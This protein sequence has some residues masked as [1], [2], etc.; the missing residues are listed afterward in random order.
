[1]RRCAVCCAT[2]TA[3]SQCG[4]CC[5]VVYCGRQCQAADWRAHHQFVCSI[6]IGLESADGV[7]IDIP[8]EQA[9]QF[10]TIAELM[11]EYNGED[12]YIPIPNVDGD[13]LVYVASLRGA[14][15]IPAITR[16]NY[17]QMIRAIHACAYLENETLLHVFASRV[18]DVL[19]AMTDATLAYDLVAQLDPF[20][21]TRYVFFLTRLRELPRFFARNFS[22]VPRLNDWV[23]RV[24][25]SK[26][27][28]R[29]R[30]TWALEWAATE[31]NGAVLDF[32]LA[33]TTQVGDAPLL[34]AIQNGHKSIVE[35]LL[36]DAR[37]DPAA[38]ISKI[39][40]IVSASKSVDVLDVLLRDGRADP[41]YDNN[42]LLNTLVDYNRVLMVK[43]LLKDTRVDPAANDSYVVY[44]AC[45]RAH[46]LML[47]ALLQDGRVDPAAAGNRA[48]LA[49]V[50]SKCVQCI[51][52]LLHAPGVDYT[53]GNGAVL[54]FATRGNHQS[55]LHHL[56]KK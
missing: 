39:W 32:L 44:V 5:N 41:A 15:D 33:A 7:R 43:R 29:L 53:A 52:L 40:I 22:D 20:L 37:V 34:L 46:I 2:R 23:Q 47:Q 38:S 3:L 9:K 4:A 11:Q 45:R 21:I 42:A 49:A 17:A 36:S 10:H 30:P 51:H 13:T 31:G 16:E 35:T 48:L 14:D 19:N 6:G 50:K 25:K 27:F 26:A 24:A 56:Q 1:M 55:L 8:A 28:E 54:Q 18:A 12:D